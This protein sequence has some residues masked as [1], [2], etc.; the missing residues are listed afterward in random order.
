AMSEEEKIRRILEL[1][2]ALR[3]LKAASLWREKVA[4]S[5]A[6]GPD[7]E[8]DRESN[9]SNSDELHAAQNKERLET[10]L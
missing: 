9:A 5:N 4:G 6:K 2:E 10:T 3:H 7:D 1:E 8:T